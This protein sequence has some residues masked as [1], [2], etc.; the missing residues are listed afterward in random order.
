[1][2]NKSPWIIKNTTIYHYLRPKE[3]KQ[4]SPQSP[5]KDKFE[6]E[7]DVPADVPAESV[8]AP[9]NVPAESED[10]PAQAVLVQRSYFDGSVVAI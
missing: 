8:G 9:V 7:A 3:T 4:G 1:M 6:F 10:F 5:Y 2:R